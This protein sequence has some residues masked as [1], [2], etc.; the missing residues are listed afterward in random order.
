MEIKNTL[1]DRLKK[2]RSIKGL[3][4]E[5][6]ARI[7][8][9]KSQTV[10]GYENNYRQPDADTLKRLA[11]I[12]SVSTDYLLGR[13]DIRETP[14]QRYILEEENNNYTT[15]HLP[16]I[17]DDLD[18]ETIKILNR[19]DKLTP[20]AKKQLEEAIKWVFELDAR[21][22]ELEEIRKNKDHE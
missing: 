11:D 18:P 8:G 1:G 10:S 20:R 22:R 14:E 4:Q 12:Y 5:D 9:V 19:A 16:P 17:F 6:V 15:G 2:A 13:S 7:I 3:T 21:E